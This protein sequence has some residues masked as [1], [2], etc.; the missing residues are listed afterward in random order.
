M[1]V[2]SEPGLGSTFS[3]TAKF[4]HPGDIKT[5]RL[6]L[7]TTE[8]RGMPVLLVYRNGQVAHASQR[9]GMCRPQHAPLDFVADVSD[10]VETGGELELF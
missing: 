10:E 3:F 8:L 9:L 1:Q 2:D 5:A 7:L 6:W 4:K